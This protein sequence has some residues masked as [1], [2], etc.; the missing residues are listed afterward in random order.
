MF[1]EINKESS[2]S[3]TWISN[4]LHFLRLHQVIYQLTL[5]ITIL[6]FQPKADLFRLISALY[7]IILITPTFLLIQDRLGKKDDEKVNQKRI[8]FSELFNKLFFY[9]SLILMISIL[10]LN[11]IESLICYILLFIS[12]LEYAAAKHYRKMGLSYA[13][14]YLSSIF[15]VLLYIFILANGLPA[16]YYLLIL[17]IPVLDL[18][19]N[20]AGDIRDIEKDT[21]A[22]IKT[23]VTYYNRST[24]LQLMSL[25]VLG[26]FGFIII[27]LE[28]ILLLILL[29]LNVIQFI[30][31]EQLPNKLSHGIFHLGKILN[32][33]IISAFLTNISVF[34][35]LPMVFFIGIAWF[36]AYY[37]YLLNTGNVSHV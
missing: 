1:L 7:M 5:V 8:I 28:S 17:F 20:I 33:L 10:A 14:R 22:G 9:F 6:F 35:L 23:L 29:L 13:G 36:L 11:N 30:V 25:I 16:E 4:L 27:H 12:T 15:T 2:L 3:I 34:L 18:I 19:G 21:K 37:F 24:T 26:L 32:F 31:I